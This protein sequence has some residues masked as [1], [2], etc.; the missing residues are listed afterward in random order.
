V[1]ALKKG[2]RHLVGYVGTMRKREGIA[3]L[4]RAARLIVNDMNRTDVHFGI[5]GGGPAL[6]DMKAY[7]KKL[8][9]AEY[10]TFTGRVPDQ[11]MLEMLNT[12]DVCVNP[13][14]GNVLND[15]S[16]M[17][18]ITE[19]MALAK[20]IVQFNLTESRFSAQEASLYAEW[21]SE[22]DLARKIVQLLDDPD[23]RA[24]MGAFGRKRVETEL[25]WKYE[26]PRLLRAYERA[27]AGR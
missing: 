2:R 4:L 24:R 23:A 26:A 20:P 15:K 10:V 5:V 25:E 11:E 8:D 1:E 19:Y 6:E 27:L 17:K 21:N 13:D 16:S 14:V 3:Y 7:A 18:R 22:L 12:A 9:L